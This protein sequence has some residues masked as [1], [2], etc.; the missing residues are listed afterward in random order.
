MSLDL[1]LSL[2]P[3]LSISRYRNY[4]TTAYLA[5]C[6]KQMFVFEHITHRWKLEIV[7]D[8]QEDVSVDYTVIHSFPGKV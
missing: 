5:L 8:K 4:A 6:L 3:T 7:I 2:E 1:S